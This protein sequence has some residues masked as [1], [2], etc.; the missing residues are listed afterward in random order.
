MDALLN[1][2]LAFSKQ[3]QNDWKET[4]EQ[5]QNIEKE[6]SWNSPE[7][8]I[9]ML[10]AFEWYTPH[11]GRHWKRLQQALPELKDIGIDNILLPPGC[12]A[13]NP[14]G[15]GYDIH[16]LYD[17]GEFDQKG[18]VAT[19]W[20]TKQDLVT[21]AQ[22][23]EQ[24]GIGIYWDAVLNHKAGADRKERCLAVTV[25]PEDRNIDL[26]KPQEIEAWVGF[27]FSNRGE[28]YSKMKYNWQHFNGTDYND[29]DH[30]SAI[31]KIFAPGKDWA[32]DVSTENGNYDYLMFAN[33]DHS[34]PEVRED[35]LN[36][37]NWI[38]AQLPL[39]GMRLDAVKHYSAEFQKLLVDHVR[40]TRKEWFF[41]SEFWSGDVLE[42]Q[43]YLKRFDYKVYAFD[44]PLCQRLSAVSQTRGADLR[45]VFEKTLVKCEPENAVTFVMNHDTQPKQAL[46]APIPPSFKPLAYALILLRKDGYPCIFYGDLYGICSSV[47]AKM[48]KQKPMTQ[49][50]IPKEL[51]GLPAMILARKLYA[52]GEQQD[53][54]LQRNCVGFVRY[55]NARH[56]A[57][58]ACVMNN[59]LTAINLR[60]HV[61]KRHAG[62]RWSDV[63]LD[64]NQALGVED[65][66]NG[67]DNEKTGKIGK[68]RVVQI[69]SK[70]YADFPV[71]SMSVGVWVNEAA[72]GRER[73]VG[74]NL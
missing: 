41:V 28:T 4:E 24:L 69:S 43:E 68:R 9:C 44:A 42:I 61:G 74:M 26:T 60:M 5:A 12:K 22:L 16:D 32:K 46:E 2:F 51:Q 37:T 56:P 66:K 3:K 38:G 71:A 40:R 48:A 8:N 52:Y 13:M 53:Y 25:D 39:R 15:N 36:W 6:P 65:L 72:E 49:S 59:G 50:R 17:L 54:F 7:D 34:H 27:D 30:K 63:L 62:E 45:L 23:A 21:L 70:G 10:E 11:D 19:K 20:G 14:S 57:G 33:L 1:C 67:K 18:T 35:I 73:F 47:P 64:N 55:G 58:L 31:Y 29:I